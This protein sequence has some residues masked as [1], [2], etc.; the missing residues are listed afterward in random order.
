[1]I[2]VSVCLSC[3]STLHIDLRSQKSPTTKGIDDED[4]DEEEEEEKSKKEVEKEVM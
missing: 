2:Y 4:E 1:M 3:V